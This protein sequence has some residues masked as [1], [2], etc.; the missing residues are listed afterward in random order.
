MIGGSLLREYCP[1]CAR[2]SKCGG[3]K[4]L[5][6]IFSGVRDSAYRIIGKKGGD[7]LRHRARA[8]KDNRSSY[9]GREL[10]SACFRAR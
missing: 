9:R 8:G 2:R 4:D 10:D 1:V 6:E 7:K 3:G 5:Q